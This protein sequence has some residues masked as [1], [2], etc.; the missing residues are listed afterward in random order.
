M[1]SDSGYP[2]TA[3]L[4][5]GGGTNLQALIDAAEAPDFPT[6]IGLVVSNVPNAYCLER[7]RAAGIPTATIDHRTFPDR[8]SFEG[9]IDITLREFGA[10]IVCLA[11]F[12]RILTENFVEAWHD[13]IL[14]VHP[15]LLPKFR[16]LDT[17]RRVL[18]AGDALHGCTVHFVRPA[19]DDGPAIVQAEV[20]VLTG[21]SPEILRQRV[22]S[23]EHIAFPTALSLVAS[24]QVAVEGD[25][26]TIDGAPGPL[27]L[28]WEAVQ[29]H[30]E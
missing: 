23:R 5:S 15:S 29:A 4:A 11:G 6:R 20:P 25:I 14:N 16:G 26:A 9:E 2:L 13:R 30:L 24:G 12:M 19:L 22:L 8:E 21:D 27:R 7:A 17:H 10:E 1:P 28:S 18:E 3:V